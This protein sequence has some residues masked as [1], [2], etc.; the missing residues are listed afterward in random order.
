MLL[1]IVFPIELLAL[2][3]IGIIILAIIGDVDDGG[4]YK[5]RVASKC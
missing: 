4:G 2:L 1:A 3:F 5:E